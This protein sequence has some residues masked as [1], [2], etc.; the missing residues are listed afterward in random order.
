MS[1]NGERRRRPTRDHAW[2]PKCRGGHRGPDNII[3]VCHGCN[4]DKGSQD[5]EQFYRRLR[6]KGDPRAAYVLGVIIRRSVAPERREARAAAAWIRPAAP[7]AAGV[8][9]RGKTVTVSDSSSAVT[10]QP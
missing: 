8:G 4:G 2:T 6:G 5:V 3:V 10:L 1:F 7:V 9:D